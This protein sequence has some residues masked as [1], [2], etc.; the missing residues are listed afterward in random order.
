MKVTTKR[1]VRKEC[2]EEIVTQDVYCDGLCGSADVT[3]QYNR[4][5]GWMGMFP[6]IGEGSYLSATQTY[7]DGRVS[8]HESLSFCSLYCATR[9]FNAALALCFLVSHPTATPV[10][11]R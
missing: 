7:P 5:I 2:E 9:Y 4:P 11:D 8:T 6:C 10:V 1:V 3:E